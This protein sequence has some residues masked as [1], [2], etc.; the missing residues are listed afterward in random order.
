MIRGWHQVGFERDVAP[1]TAS[2]L[3]DLPLLLAR[4]DAGIS[5]FD[6]TCPHRGADLGHGGCLDGDAVICP[7]HGLRISLGGG[8]DLSVAER[9]SLCIGGLIFTLSAPEDD[10]GYRAYIMARERENFVV[11]GFAMHVDTPAALVIENAFDAAHFR[12]VHRILNEPD[13]EVALSPGGPLEARGTFVVPP[14]RWQQGPAGAAIEV[15]VVARAFSPG[16]VVTEM[17]GA[18]PYS[19]LTA[20][21]P[22]GSEGK[23]CEIRLSLIVPPDASG[24]APS[25]QA[26]EYL[27]RQS[28]SGLEADRRI[29]ERLRPPA[30]LRLTARDRAVEAFAAFC[31]QF[32]EASA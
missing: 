19:V 10:R 32:A 22:E 1:I 17:G 30:R 6:G 13:F 14:S 24:A 29:W 21:T 2:T 23:A 15:R 7:F 9:D 28:R 8:D 31:A 5:V 11:P 27:L 26:C 16:L 18:A 3:G 20:A 12:P 4:R 25:A